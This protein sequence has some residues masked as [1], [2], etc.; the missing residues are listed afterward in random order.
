MTNKSL[1][2]R[3]ALTVTS[4]LFVQF[5]ATTSTAEATTPAPATPTPTAV[6]MRT[7]ITDPGEKALKA[8]SKVCV[9]YQTGNVAVRPDCIKWSNQGS[10]KGEA[11]VPAGTTNI[12]VRAYGFVFRG[13]TLDKGRS[14]ANVSSRRINKQVYCVRAVGLDPRTGPIPVVSVDGSLSEC[15]D[16]PVLPLSRNVNSGCK[17]DEYAFVVMGC[18]HQPQPGLTYDDG[19]AFSFIIP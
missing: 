9:N 14:S 15:P 2:F 6:P 19:N 7:P 8:L 4:A 16:K 18:S 3:L 10:L 1:I 5:T 17:N 13:G 11:E 12:G